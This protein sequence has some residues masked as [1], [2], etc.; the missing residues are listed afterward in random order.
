MSLPKFARKTLSAV[1]NSPSLQVLGMGDIY[2]VLKE[3]FA[4]SA[5]EM[6]AICV[7]HYAYWLGTTNPFK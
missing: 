4:L 7:I 3:H 5:Q 6:E 2:G 1:L